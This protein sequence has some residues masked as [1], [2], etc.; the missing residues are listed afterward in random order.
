MVSGKSDSRRPAG[1]DTAVADCLPDIRA[2]ASGRYAISVG[3]SI[4]KGTSDPYSDIDFRL[5]CD[6]RAD[7]PHFRQRRARLQKRINEWAGRGTIIDGC[8]VR[9]I[10]ETERE[11]R[12]WTRGEGEPSPRVWTI[13]GYYLPT[14]LYNQ[15]VLEDPFGVIAEWKT[16]LTP[17][18][19]AMKRATIDRHRQSLEY[20]MRD[21]HYANKVER[22]DAV[23]LSAVTAKMMRD[24][25]QL[26]FAVNEIYFPGD[27]KNLE[28]IEGAPIVPSDLAER[29]RGILYPASGFNGLA[30]QRDDLGRLGHEVLELIDVKR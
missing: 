11:L 1:F 17:Y 26:L 14:D 3:G 12:E 23:F 4:G 7:E 6:A 8:W 30:R 16:R 18:P 28:L 10:D 27:G 20:W 19:V 15:Y 2:L 5:F 22:A 29:V 24:I 25:L 13:W 21:Y 9:T